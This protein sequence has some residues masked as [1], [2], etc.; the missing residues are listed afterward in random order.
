MKLSQF[1]LKVLFTIN[2]DIY[3]RQLETHFL[4]SFIWDNIHNEV[5]SNMSEDLSDLEEEEKDYQAFLS[6]EQQITNALFEKHPNL[7]DS[8]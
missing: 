6:F 2:K 3:I 4:K 7:F 1:W 5:I 8:Q